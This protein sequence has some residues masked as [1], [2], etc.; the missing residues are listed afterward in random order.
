MDKFLTFYDELLHNIARI[1][2]HTLELIGITIII[3]GSILA[4]IRVI[5]NLHAK[6]AKSVII[7]LGKSLALALEFKMGAEIINTVI[8]RELEELLILGV[9]IALRAILAILIHWEIKTE[10]KDEKV[11]ESDYEEN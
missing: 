7:G 2:V 8:V 6:K 10:K 1:T 11:S 4:L 3:I 9:I 5:K